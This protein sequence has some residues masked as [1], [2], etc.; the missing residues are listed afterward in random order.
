MKVVSIDHVQLAMPAGR[1]A[2]ACATLA[3]IYNWFTEGLRHRRPEGRQGT[4]RGN[5]WI[6]TV[7]FDDSHH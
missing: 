3:E 1:E 7:A 4:A 6:D 5:G 2:E